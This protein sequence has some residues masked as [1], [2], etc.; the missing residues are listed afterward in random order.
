MVGKS[1]KPHRSLLG[2]LVL[3]VLAATVHAQ[4]DD[5]DAGLDAFWTLDYDTAIE[6]LTPLAE[7]GNAE[8]AYFLGLLHDPLAHTVH[9]LNAVYMDE[10][11]TAKALK[12]AQAML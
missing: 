10:E 7:S 5:S 1:L 12:L 2:S 6:K 11:E 9:G 4:S 3:I 8:A